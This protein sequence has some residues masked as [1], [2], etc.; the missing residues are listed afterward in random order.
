[1]Q[2][3]I[4][5]YDCFYFY[6][7]IGCFSK[8]ALHYTMNLELMFITS[9]ARCRFDPSSPA[10]GK[11]RGLQTQTRFHYLGKRNLCILKSSSF[12][13]VKMN[14]YQLKIHLFLE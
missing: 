8:I 5:F 7:K 10:K 13:D 3:Q 4:A 9:E 11:S 14:A 2:T 1:M 6:V 12:V